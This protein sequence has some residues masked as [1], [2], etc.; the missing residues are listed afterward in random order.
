MGRVIRKALLFTVA[1][2]SVMANCFAQDLSL[3]SAAAFNILAGEKVVNNGSTLVQGNVGVG[4]GAVLTGF[5]PGSIKGEIHVNNATSLNALSDLSAAYQANFQK[6]YNQVLPNTLSD[7]AFAPGVYRINGTASIKGP[8]IL[9][10]NN[11]P[12]ATFIFQI[13][14]DLI[15]DPNITIALI[16]G[17]RVNNVLWLVGE[18]AQVGSSAYIK[19]NLVANKNIAV[20]DD[21]AIL[22][23]IMS[24]GGSI[25]LSNNI[26]SQPT[27]LSIEKTKVSDTPNKKYAVGDTVTY[28][29]KIRNLGPVDDE[30]VMVRDVLPAGLSFISATTSKAGTSYDQTYG[31][32]MVDVLKVGEVQTLTIKARATMA[33]YIVNTATVAGSTV[34]EN[35]NNNKSD[36]DLCVVLSDA[37]EI[38]GPTAVCAGSTNTYNIKQIPGATYT[39]SVP[40]DW[41]ITAGSRNSSEITV[42]IGNTSGSISVTVNNICG[43]SPPSRL[44]V[45]VVQNVPPKPGP[46]SGTLELCSGKATTYS[47]A[48]VAGAIGYRWTL[49]AGWTMVSDNGTS[50]VVTTDGDA[51]T[52]R[53]S[54]SA[55]NICGDGEP[56]VLDV[57]PVLKVPNQPGVISGPAAVCSTV[58]SATYSI[59]KV[60]NAS[61]YTWTVPAGWVILS[62]QGTNTITV[63]PTAQAGDITVKALNDCGES[64]AQKLV[65]TPVENPPLA[66]GAIKGADAVCVSSAGNV[67]SIDAV[68]N[69]KGYTWTVPAGWTIVS[70]QNTPTI[71][72]AAGTTGGKITVVALNDCGSNGSSSKDIQITDA[73]PA[74]PTAIKGTPYGCS[75][76]TATYTIDPVSGA[77]GYT[78]TVPAGWTIISG[79]NTTTITVK[80]GSGTGTIS[81]KAKGSCG[82]GPAKSLTVQPQINIPA[83][84]AAIT[85]PDEVCKSQA[86]LTYSVTP[87]AGVTNYSWSVPQGWT[88]VSGQGTATIKVTAGTTPG[89]ITVKAT[90]DCGTST[91]QIKAVKVSIEAPATPGPITGPATVCG[92]QQ[93]I[94]YSIAAV[95][96]ATSYEWSAPGWTITSGQGTT[97]ITVT[98]GTSAT[99]IKVTAKNACGLGSSNSLQVQVTNTPPPAPTAIKG[100]PYSCAT[101]TATYTIDAVAGATGYVWSVPAGW[102][103]VSGQN[104]TSIT[105]KV[106][107]GAGTISVK[108]KGACGDGPAQTLTVQPQTNIPAAP[109]AI[110]GPSEVCKSQAGLIYSVVPVTGVSTYTWSVPTGWTIVSGQ[111]TAT[112]T[113]TAGA[114]NGNITVTATNDCGTS[115]AQQF[116]VKVSTEA[117]ANPGAITGIATACAGQQNITYSIAAVAGATSYEWSVPGW[118]I[119]SGQGTTTITVNAGAGNTTITVVAKNACGNTSSTTKQIQVTDAVPAAPTAIKGTPYGCSTQTATYTIDPV[120][121]A[122]GYTWTV[123][124]GWTIVSGQNTTTITVKVGSGTGTI[125][126]KAKG[127]CG[128]GPA[129]SLTVQPQIN[130][131]AAPAAITGP[132]EV[133]KSQT[134]LTYSVTPVAGV[135]NYSWSVP[136]GW[137]IVSGQ[138][139]ATIKVTAGTSPG[140]ITVKATNDCGTSTAQI[141]AVKVSTEAPA[142]PGTITGP[143]T[144]CGGQ[145]SITYSIAAVTGATTYEWSAPGWTIVSGQG[146]TT[147]TVTAGATGTTI[148]VIA[149][150]A[151]GNTSPA[152]IAAVVTQSI[153][154]KPGA[155]TGTTATCVGKDQT[156][157]VPAVSGATS[158]NWTVPAGWTIVSQNGNTLIVKAGT[159]AGTI[160]VAAVN[161]CGTGPA[162]TLAV[163]PITG[164][165]TG[166]NGITGNAAVCVGGT[167]TFSVPA[168]TNVSKYT[169]EV[170]AGWTIV[171]GQG[172]TEITVKSG[173]A[174]GTIKLTA[175]ND[176]SAA[177]ITRDI[178]I[179][180]A[181]PATP[182]TIT[183]NA[184]ACSGSAQTYS[185]APVNGAVSYSWSVPQGWTIVAG[186][187]TTEI[188]VQAGATQ[189]EITVTAVNPCGNSSSASTKTI[190][191]ISSA[192]AAGPITGTSAICGSTS[193]LTYSIASVSGA[194]NYSWSV[195]QGWTIVS[196]QGTNSITVNAGT[197]SGEVAVTA[198]NSCGQG[199]SSTLA[200]TMP[201]QVNKPGPIIG[202]MDACSSLP[203]TQYSITPVQ[204]A[205]GYV[206]EVP[207]G[208]TLVAGQGS[209]SI[210]VNVTSAPGTIKVKAVNA[211]TQSAYSELIVQPVANKP[212]NPAAVQGPAEVCV[213]R[214]VTY[215]VH[216]VDA[217]SSYTWVV[218][219]TWRI[220]SGQGTNQITV[221]VG[222]LN[223]KVEVMANNGCGSSGVTTKE[224]RVLELASM[225]EIKDLSNP[226][227]GLKYM[228]DPVPGATSYNWTLP[229]GW[230]IIAGDGTNIIMV[231][232]GRYDGTISVTAD[233]G[234]CGTM[235]SSIRTDKSLQDTEIVLPNVF[236]PNND[237]NHDTWVISSFEKFT[238]NEITILNR[239]GTEVFKAKPYKNNWTGDNLS[240]G[241]YYYVGRVKLCDGSYRTLK[242]YVM[243]IR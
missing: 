74:A 142:T 61:S 32:W 119:V 163:T 23:R 105:V 76:Q 92:G 184:S 140:D 108:A 199:A 201:T 28:Q 233:N 44:T 235:P 187:G 29:I 49:P 94:T 86:E 115:T 27:D 168:G 13:T 133:C 110:N 167:A 65:V 45:E 111:G 166:I 1:F 17:A 25:T 211:C 15:V 89:D 8:I 51:T 121:G 69:A 180:T 104:T 71:T 123:P 96:G 47:I 132:D 237:G 124:A 116:P 234:V 19:G 24:L 35:L 190:S 127:S 7:E 175:S 95:T 122:I 97:T 128:D 3:G 196:G 146:T 63:K 85:G 93:S 155:I 136:Q 102:T 240:E 148:S 82:D 141:K 138:G 220:V 58:A 147:I 16:N 87:V 75:T 239:W 59:S 242:G 34:D 176:C 206:W 4:S 165:I 160:S 243:I 18:N 159:T 186:Q 144:V 64:T 39:W 112:I 229:D 145:Q 33:G 106:G 109:A 131:P 6:T 222:A 209:T 192:P 73:V 223:G 157:T 171:S 213:G 162:T 38:Q 53:L 31:L 118:V 177:T 10:A 48:P 80:V 149:K 30:L 56:S 21:A 208:W 238:D 153:P 226:C 188:T 91:A 36:A 14:K 46:I 221:T 154:A 139:T 217:A 232:A 212:A 72:V 202:F 216:T 67:Y 129:K 50:I 70:G 152:Q 174:K 103:I 107:I 195:P 60:S 225:G 200:V 214:D 98:P 164:A 11:N 193:G 84:P 181:L 41:V 178:E 55:Y 185:I 236:S 215:S 194:T 205:T 219:A 169:W 52:K 22:G 135:T 5:A 137:A 170:P 42:R 210:T 88:I 203:T 151:C 101:T 90:N 191:I 83:T 100:T 198:G 99:T 125:S 207:L 224:V 182:G 62:G 79:Q 179:A 183:G 227:E 117:P 204:G 228:V 114:T 156:Y 126:V 150:N 43:A 81:V 172:T 68:P 54:V 9:N 189:G 218:P 12:N 78:W 134:E 57:T 66:P 241:T 2:F 197:N 231:Q 130:I 113:V 143:A 26:V 37:G 173:T 161:G 20:A 230:K 158:Y 77:I 120:A 40:S